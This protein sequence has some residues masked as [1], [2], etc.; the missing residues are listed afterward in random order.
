M[1]T[2]YTRPQGFET[3]STYVYG[4]MRRPAHS[5]LAELRA[6]SSLIFLIMIAVVIIMNF[7]IS[8]KIKKEKTNKI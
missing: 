4:A 1:I 6:L 5:Y 7:R 2:A 3:I 8:S